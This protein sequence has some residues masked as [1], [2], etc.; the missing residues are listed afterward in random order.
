MKRYLS[1]AAGAVTLFAL[2]AT[3][4]FAQDEKKETTTT[5]KIEDVIVITPKVN[6]DTKLT[7]E[8][9]EKEFGSDVGKLVDGVT[10]LKKI[11]YQPEHVKQAE[12]FRKFLLAISEDI[13][14]LLVKLADRLHNMRTMYVMSL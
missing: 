3:A 4:S 13:R 5:K 8:E 12:N 11:E 14:V 7:I 2:F 1:K 9:I 10:K 6:V